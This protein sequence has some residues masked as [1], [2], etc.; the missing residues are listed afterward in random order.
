MKKVRWPP[1]VALLLASSVLALLVASARAGATKLPPDRVKQTTKPVLALA[2][3]GPRVAYM[4]KSRRVGVWNVV[5]GTTSLIKGNYPSK[6]A[7]QMPAADGEVAIAGKRVA[8]ITRFASG[9]TLETSERLYTASLGGSA[10]QLGV[11]TD[12]T[13][14]TGDCVTGDVGGGYGDWLGGLVG[15]GKVLAVSSWQADGTATSRERLRLIV[16]AGPQTIATGPGAI[17][18]QS[19]DGSHI[20]V[21]R[22]TDAWPFYQGPPQHSTP[23][24]GI[25]SAAGRRLAEIALD[26]PPPPD[27]CGSADDTIIQIALSG[28][29]LVVL[30]QDPQPGT[31]ATAVEVYDWRTGELLHTWPIAPSRFPAPLLLSGRIAVTGVKKLR[32]LDVTTGKTATIN[33]PAPDWQHPAAIGSRGLV[34]T[35]GPE[36]G[37]T[38]FV[39]VPRAKLRA[40]LSQ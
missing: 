7:K 33:T 24:V 12:H 18:S 9:N 10:R 3:D 40:M 15:S 35:V 22:S 2:M 31:A 36:R 20:A 6:G 32:L 29:T 28:N 39:F 17:V 8:L 21:L 34:Y 27:P 16:P 5:T 30:K 13:S 38:R 37:P 25:Y 23:E 4:L 1:G 26:V 19:A 14:Y 11:A